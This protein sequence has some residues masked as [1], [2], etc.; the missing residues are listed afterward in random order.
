[1]A[2]RSFLSRRKTTTVPSAGDDADKEDVD[3]ADAD[4]EDTNKKG[5][6]DWRGLTHQIV[7]SLPSRQ[8]TDSTKQS[9][10]YMP[11]WR[12]SSR[13]SDSLH[14]SRRST[15]LALDRQMRRSTL[16]VDDDQ[17]EDLRHS[18]LAARKSSEFADAVAGLV[19]Q[20]RMEGPGEEGKRRS[21]EEIEDMVKSM[22]VPI[23]VKKMY[24]EALGPRGHKKTWRHRLSGFEDNLVTAVKMDLWSHHFRE[25]EGR[26]GSATA[27]YFRFVR[28][29]IYLNLFTFFVS[30]FF[31]VVPF[32]VGSQPQ[33]FGEDTKLT[34]NN[35]YM[36][37][38]K[39]C[40]EV[41]QQTLRNITENQETPQKV[42]GVII[43]RGYMEKTA[44]FYGVYY[45]RTFYKGTRDSF[46][47]NMGMAYVVV[48]FVTFVVTFF[49][50]VTNTSQAVKD[51][52][53]TDEGQSSV[54]FTNSV[55]C[56][57]DYSINEEKAAN[58]K[59][60]ILMQEFLA[61]LS[62]IKKK[63]ERDNRTK[64]QKVVFL[65]IRIIINILVILIELGSLYLIYY[66]TNLLIVSSKSVLSQSVNQPIMLLIVQ[67][68]PSL[69][70][71]AINVV[72][73]VL[74]DLFVTIEDYRPATMIKVTLMRWVFLRLSALVV[75]IIAM[76]Y[77]LHIGEEVRPAVDCPEEMTKDVKRCCSNLIW[78]VERANGTSTLSNIRCW[79]TYVGQQF[80]KFA[81]VDGV[82]QVVKVFLVEIPRKWVFDTFRERVSLVADYGGQYLDLA[83]VV[84]DI[85]YMQCLNWLGM[86]FTPLI[87]V[88]TCVKMVI[89]F[90]LKKMTLLRNYEPMLY[91][92][93]GSTANS[94]FMCIL[95]IGFILSAT[96]VGYIIRNVPP[97]KSCG[98]FRV[99][100]H[101]N[102]T[103]WNAL[104]IQVATWPGYVSDFLFFFG[105]G[106]FFAPAAIVLFLMMLH[107]WGSSRAYGA[108]EKLLQSQLKM[109]GRDKQ[110]LLKRVNDM[111]KEQNEDQ[112]DISLF[113]S[114][115]TE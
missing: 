34:A 54:H 19:E 56:A 112:H 101:D 15:T 43:G 71:C 8:K 88:I 81:I 90:F 2:V 110:V 42:L 49:L 68:L 26:F 92:Y 72:V 35:T 58:S 25:I 27:S 100:A 96:V 102:Y 21:Q 60:Q 20:M 28:W 82:V 89:L 109:E 52:M 12:S 38:A 67:F 32:I 114:D 79:E 46:E 4:N 111:I 37:K 108:M 41:Y 39:R 97:S 98:P 105:T 31:I 115:E 45:N 59:K 70:I 75:V 113:Q 22:P 64:R 5:K 48:I 107:Y 29:V 94:F 91:V 9:F 66:T 10:F 23:S 57:W 85:V 76:G 78:D 13:Q 1:M 86:Y 50:I 44:M 14:D 83:E 33:S 16:M 93:K 103:M 11:G 47:Y 40:S 17:P 77:T 7:S 69:A 87:S 30:F 73:P 53:T 63:I 55:L 84:L 80:Y 51:A 24:R 104:T 62:A 95:L 99:H 18:F 61:D 6:L 65:M 36:D 74:L 106:Y 3:K